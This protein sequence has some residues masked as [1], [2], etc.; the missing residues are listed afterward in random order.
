MTEY[1]DKNGRP[2]WV[3]ENIFPTSYCEWLYSFVA[4]SLYTIGFEDTDV[5]ERR[6]KMYIISGYSN[7]DVEKSKF[8]LQLQK[9][10]AWDKVKDCTLY[11]TTINLSV[12]TNTHYSHTHPDEIALIY[13][14][15]LDWKQEWAGETLF[16]SDDLK[17]IIHASMYKP[18]KLII[19]DGNIPHTIRPQNIEAP[20]FRFSI[21]MFFKKPGAQK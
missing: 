18:N 6:N 12:P 2:I 4:H 10:A 14:V 5:I 3:Y 20:T 13:Y 1:I 11:R 7:A 15:N 16:Y 9:T 8:M 17:D 21:A 19:F